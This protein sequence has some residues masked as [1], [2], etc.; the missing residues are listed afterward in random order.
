MLSN[1]RERNLRTA[2]LKHTLQDRVAVLHS[3]EKEYRLA[4]PC[5]GTGGTVHFVWK[6]DRGAMLPLVH[7]PKVIHPLCSARGLTVAREVA[8]EDDIT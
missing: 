7:V 2:Y 4:V 6:N 5:G 1:N 8:F 3:G